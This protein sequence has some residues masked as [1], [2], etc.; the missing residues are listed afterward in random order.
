MKENI[1]KYV[2]NSNIFILSSITEGLPTVLLEALACGLPIISTNCETGPIEI[3]DR[4]HYGFLVKVG[5][6]KDLAEKMIYLASNK[7]KMKEYSKKSLKRAEFFDLEKIS[8]Q[9]IDLIE[10]L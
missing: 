5:D 10:T 2:K 9:W 6:A 1:Y 4:G 7:D 8:K 3:L